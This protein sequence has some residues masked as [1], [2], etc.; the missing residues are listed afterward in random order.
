MLFKILLDVKSVV[1][2]EWIEVGKLK[3]IDFIYL[4]FSIWVII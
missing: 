1:I 3:F 2:I 4:I